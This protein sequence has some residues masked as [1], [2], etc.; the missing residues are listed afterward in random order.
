MFQ[1]THAKIIAGTSVLAC[2]ASQTLAQQDPSQQDPGQPSSRQSAPEQRVVVMP[3]KHGVAED[4][5][6]TLQRVLHGARITPEHRTNSLIVMGPPDAIEDAKHLLAEID[7]EVDR[8]NPSQSREKLIRAF[9]LQHAEA[10]NRMLATLSQLLRS[11]DRD[12]SSLQLALDARQNQVIASGN[13]AYLEALASLLDM[14]DKP[15]TTDAAGATGELS[16]RL[17]WLVGGD[18]GATRDVPNDLKPVTDEL[19]RYGVG[20]LKLGAQSILRVASEEEFGASFTSKLDASWDHQI[21]GRVRSTPDE[22]LRLEIRVL[23]RA[24][25]RPFA[26]DPSQ[27][28][29]GVSTQFETTITTTAGHFVVLSMNP[30]GD[31]DSVFVLQ[32]NESN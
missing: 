23:A 18:S 19:A 27:F 29:S 9:P 16:V 11:S 28:A 2:L 17:L 13:A 30:V 20:G 3:L 8:Q 24:A 25:P 21:S 31:M 4:V 15:A 26:N 7:V 14:M 1:R 12:M 22:T 6:A 5:G 32:I 10:D